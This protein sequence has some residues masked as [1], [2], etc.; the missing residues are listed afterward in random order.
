MTKLI[1]SFIVLVLS[2]AFA[3]LYVLPA[4]NVSK[5]RRADIETLSKNLSTSDE[6]IQ[7][8]ADTKNNLNSIESIKLARFE[9]FLPEEIDP[10]RFANNIQNIG[11][12]NMVSMISIE[13]DTPGQD[14][15]QDGT[16]QTGANQLQLDTNLNQADGINVQVYGIATEKEKK[17]A[18][19]KATITFETSFEKFKLFLS[20]LERSL[21]LMDVT[22]LSF[23][24]S[25]ETEETKMATQSSPNYKFLMTIETYSLK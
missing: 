2:A 6:I 13:V 17:Y 21:G 19:T 11:T 16:S 24:V 23:V 22:A 3:F 18:T 4:Y 15:Q 8:I 7:L 14:A 25:S 9:V 10:I 1:T 12:D 20:D 5:E